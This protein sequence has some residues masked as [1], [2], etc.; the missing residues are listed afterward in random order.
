MHLNAFYDLQKHTY[1]DALIQPVHQKDD[2]RAFCDMVDRHHVLPDTNDAFIGDR[3][4][5]SYNNMAHV[6]EKIR[7]SCFA[8]KTFFQRDLLKILISL[9][10][11]LLIFR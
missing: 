1:S 11:I 3:G 9:I 4:Y 7:I 10:Q 6:L 5:C 2:F 8:Q